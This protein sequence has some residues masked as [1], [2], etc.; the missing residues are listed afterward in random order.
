MVT[1]PPRPARTPAPPPA[2]LIRSKDGASLTQR[3]AAERKSEGP[4]VRPRAP[5]PGAEQR[6]GLERDPRGEQQEGSGSKRARAPGGQQQNS[7]LGPKLVETY[8]QLGARRAEVSGE[9]EDEEEVKGA[10]ELPCPLSAAEL[11]APEGVFEGAGSEGAP[12]LLGDGEHPFDAIDLDIVSVLSSPNLLGCGSQ[13]DAPIAGPPQEQSTQYGAQIVVGAQ[14]GERQRRDGSGG[15]GASE[16]DEEDDDDLDNY[17]NFARTV[18]TEDVME[19]LASECFGLD[20]GEVPTIDQLDGV[21]D[22]DSGGGGAGDGGAG[23]DGGQTPPSPPPPQPPPVPAGRPQPAPS[24]GKEG[25]EPGNILP[26]EIMDFVL[27]NTSSP[28]PLP[29]PPADDPHFPEPPRIQRACG[30]LCA[31]PHPAVGGGVVLLN[32]GGRHVVI[33]KGAEERGS[34]G[35]GGPAPTSDPSPRPPEPE[36]AYVNPQPRAGYGTVLLGAPGPVALLRPPQ[37]PLPSP[38]PPSPLPVLNL[39]LGHHE[40]PVTCLVPVPQ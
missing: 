32:N 4:C 12:S 16:E 22:S 1:S 24:P 6:N 5:P 40:P 9:E 2:P 18:V 38:P 7:P 25:E 29:V 23:G 17:Y 35:D 19:Q 37:A 26:S 10:L 27:K 15:G 13:G 30:G 11:L 39:V 33:L 8:V 20:S 14:G 21:D 34:G 28:P 3:D 36:A 31:E